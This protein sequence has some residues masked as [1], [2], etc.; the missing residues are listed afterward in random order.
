MQLAYRA[1]QQ[2]GQFVDALSMY[3]MLRMFCVSLIFLLLTTTGYAVPPGTTI[4]NIATANFDVSG[5][6]QTRPSNNVDII[7]TVNLSPATIS[8]LQYSP[9]GSGATPTNSSPTGC[10][11]SGISGP[12]NPLANPTYAGVGTLNVAAPI[13][14]APASSYHQGEPIFIQV[15]DSNRNID[16]GVRDTLVITISSSSVGDVENLE[17]TETDINTG[18][19]V[20]YIQSVTTPVT[21]NDCVLAVEA[22][23]TIFVSYTDVF[24]VT[25]VASNNI[26][27][28][29][30]GIVFN[31]TTGQPVNGI[32]VTLVDAATNLPAAVF[33][34]DLVSAFPSTVVTGSTVT[35]AGSTV[36][37]F[38]PGVYRFP[39]V[40]PGTYRIEV[41]ASEYVVPSVVSE[42]QLQT[43]SGAPYALDSNASFGQ[44]FILVVGPPLNVDIPIDPIEDVLFVTKQASEQEV[45]IGDFMQYEINVANN[46]P[47][48]IAADV[49]V[50]DRLPTGF[51]LQSG[52]VR[53]DGQ[54]V[55]DPDQDETGGTLT[56]RLGNLAASSNVIIK[57]VVEVSSGA[58]FGHATNSAQANDASGISS[59]IA[60]ATVRVKDDLLSTRSF[61][62]GSVTEGSCELINQSEI[63]NATYQL[64]SEKVNEDT[65][66]HTVAM[67]FNNQ[68]SG[69][70]QLEVMLPNLL[71]YE[72][73]TLYL[74]G[75]SIHEPSQDGNKI[76]IHIPEQY[77]HGETV[78]VFS[79]KV[80]PTLIGKFT[81]KARL[82]TQ[83]NLHSDWAINSFDSVESDVAQQNNIDVI[84]SLSQLI[85]TNNLE[86][87]SLKGVPGIK[88]MLEDGRYVLTDDR[89]LYHF[90][91]IEPGTHV[92]QIDP[93]SIPEHLEVAGCV[94]NT[95][96]AG[97]KYSRFVDIEPGLIWRANFYLKEKVSTQG[98]INT[99][100]EST[101]NGEVIEYSL[102]ISGHSQA[103]ENV[104][105][106]VILPEG[107]QYIEGSSL[108]DGQAMIDPNN[109][110]GTMTYTL[111]DQTSNEWSKT[112]IFKVE[113][114]PSGQGE[115]NA[116][117]LVTYNQGEVVNQRSDLLQNTIFFQKEKRE[118][119]RYTLRP[120]FNTLSADLNQNDMQEI[121]TL[122]EKVGTHTI[123]NIEVTGHTD[124][125]P[126]SNKNKKYF[127][128]NQALSM[129]RAMSVA[130]YI[131]R[132]LDLSDHQVVIKGM[133]AE[134]PVADNSRARGR[135]L[136]R[137][138]EISF[139]VVEIVKN[140]QL[141]VI[142]NESEKIS[143][144]LISKTVAEDINKN[145]LPEISV[146]SK[147]D[148]DK[149]W[150]DSADDSLEW[151]LPEENANPEISSV[152]I[153]IKHSQSEKIE[154]RLNGEKVSTLNLDSRLS[155]SDGSRA[156]TR[157]RGVDIQEGDNE[158]EVITYNVDDV[159]QQRL[160]K[161]VHLS[162]QP[163]RAELVPEYSRLK[164]NGRYPI[165][166]AVRFY[167]QWG[168][169]ARPG[170]VGNYQLSPGYIDSTLKDQLE[171]QPLNGLLK[172]K[173]RYKVARDG[174][175]FI[176]I[177]P[178][179]KSGKVELDFEF[180][181]DR[182]QTLTAWL[183]ADLQEW[184]LVGL[185][186]GTAGYNNVSGN[187]QALDDHQHEENLYEDGRLAFYGK[188]RVKGEWLLTLAYD[189]DR[190]ER[191]S[192]TRLFQTVD[193]DEYYTLYGDATEQQFDAASE[194]KIYLKLEKHQFYA[195]FGDF[196]TGMTV[197]ELARYSR[198]MTG[199]KSEYEGEQYSF[200]SFAA[201]T[202]QTFARDEI[203]GNGTSGLYRLTNNNIVINSEKIR[204]E[205]RD[206]FQ[207]QKIVSEQT[208][209]QFTDYSIDTVNG[210]LFFKQPIQ[211]RDENFNPI[212]IVADYEVIGSSKRNVTA[213]GRASVYTKDRKVEL[214]I[215]GVSQEDTRVEGSLIATDLTYK[216]SDQTELRLEAASSRT[217]D[218]DNR[219][220]ST[221][222]L[223]ELEHRSEKIDANTYFRRQ[224]ESFGLDQQSLNN[225]GS[226]RYGADARYK[227][228]ETININGEA[229]R[230][231]SL[232][233]NNKRSVA[234]LEIEKAEKIYQVAAGVKYANDE[235]E[236]EEDSDSVL[237][238]ARASRYMFD[239]KVQLRGS[240]EVEL[241]NDN[242]SDHPSRYIAG[243][244][245]Q[246]NN[247][248][249]LFAEH[250]Y[251]DGDDQNTNTSRVGTRITPW[252]Q[253]TINTSVE[254]QASEDGSRVFSNLG[255]VQGWQYND[256]LQLD[257][258]LD[259]SDTLRNPGETLFNSNV[260]LSSGTQSND[261]TAT[262]IGANYT[263]DKWAS[264]S[265]IEYRTS[266]DDI[267]RGLYVGY[268]REENTGIGM[269]FDAQAFDLDR[270][271]GEDESRADI[272]FSV[273]YRPDNSEWTVL[274]R[275]D[276]NYEDRHGEDS[277]IRTRKSV[278]NLNINYTM[279]NVHQFGAHWGIKYTLDNIDGEEYD[280]LTQ[281]V[282]FQ[283]RY[284]WSPKLD[285]SLHGDILYSSNS[286][287][288]KYSLGPSVG[289][290]VYKNMWLSVGYN[291]D[292]FEDDDFTSSDYTANGPYVKLRLK[293]DAHT[294]K[295]L[296]GK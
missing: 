119:Q 258:S 296:L 138:V 19:F 155:S 97:A 125:V 65:M 188:G 205:T 18:V 14:L 109:T 12:Y 186:E 211:S 129:A 223:A 202:D 137:R 172:G 170:I 163:V 208:L 272:N 229:Y 42:G 103:I 226:K 31:S 82:I 87:K 275:F 255:F 88:L 110:F 144:K 64:T 150:L 238:T 278:N 265:R 234:S 2:T 217:K 89:G 288:Y 79:T 201:D 248:T 183:N 199:L 67:K 105:A 254:Q 243:A 257:F 13:D 58:P 4:S 240:A 43:L 160:T 66:S 101:I 246:L 36:Y 251:T 127:I 7:T 198:S 3:A 98:V 152:D 136:N 143:T 293:F 213:G 242:S 197:T 249:E 17:L 23:E 73:G 38:G 11:M 106:S 92:V 196:D 33:G 263:Q 56:F 157:W 252:N 165:V 194:R 284:D 187:A 149:A 282:G 139:N 122:I 286:D 233:E 273:A 27:V 295:G 158:F 285:L 76:T 50:I 289:I 189:S 214:G 290:N 1:Y 45:S 68:H 132:H 134:N 102:N 148:F 260:P 128:D 173:T 203:Q 245:Y 107:M 30:F 162:G 220:S 235:L 104:R 5:I 142:T 215:S 281:L 207:P 177:E 225:D 24:D 81:L 25:D 287:N 71:V 167:D 94:N 121:I 200:N 219:E 47:I 180:I 54:A 280:G 212:Y 175:A 41:S 78:L 29:P 26:L 133:G 32:T 135:A 269:S 69:I 256:N 113:G 168:H 237:A 239:S 131:K 247:I 111:G 80:D 241:S 37:N 192:A 231:E 48:D 16:V 112:I 190:K 20:G 292:G 22:N 206:R 141:E 147:P 83:E 262:S 100:L 204:L 77:Q 222:Y 250:E 261:F 279:D 283:Y 216:V 169:H 140:Q 99:Q 195:L 176:E 115:V 124:N 70:T 6:P 90:E 159:E 51:R 218:S 209:S 151:L 191:N 117:V 63:N 161:R 264:S 34:D 153:A 268:Y 227:I 46:R 266:D 72:K 259:R 59:N 28:D 228:N 44:N 145:L 84:T 178:T 74:N 244:D 35:D 85:N 15:T 53:I 130:N 40:A 274:N 174:I 91:A 39:S 95:R 185:A 62:I 8:F 75:A 96:S 55:S 181:D 184:V 118:N 9:T 93:A 116:Q 21:P 179:T 236:D 108:L 154:L 224:G 10:S 114:I 120:S 156:I 253:A 166:I 57:Y 123:E 276:V 126:I 182:E 221:A 271:D 193:P 210:T 171:K 294:I 291:I 267:Q 277:R 164:A 146:S 270:N 61:L 86:D 49:V 60:Q 232:R 230:D 52:S